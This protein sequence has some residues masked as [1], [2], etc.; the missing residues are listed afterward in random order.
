[1]RFTAW[2]FEA[3]HKPFRRTQKDVPVLAADQ[4]LVEVVGCGVCHTD[5]GFVYDGVP[6]RHA[7]P[8]V[9]GHEISGKV[10]DAGTGSKEWVGKAVVLPAVIPCG[11]CALCKKGHSTICAKQIFFGNDMD[12]GFASHVVAPSRGLCEVPKSSTIDL[13]SLSVLAD[14]ITTPF[15][16]IKRA[17]LQ[18]GDFAIF[19]GVGGVGAFGVQLAAAVG[20]T[21]VAIDVDPVRLERA[22]SYGA[23]LTIN[24]CDV[25]EKELKKRLRAYAKE[26]GLP[27]TQWKIFETS[28]TPAGQKTAFAML[29]HGAHLAIVGYTPRNVEICLSHL[30]AFDARAEGN[31]GCPPEHYPAAL[32]MILS[33]KLKLEPFIERHPMSEVNHVFHALHTKEITKRVVLTPDF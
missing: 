13:A 5:L 7:L 19:V 9:L 29:V 22:A 12:G 33:G 30:M 17:G 15:Q 3:P 18:K 25:E 20:A 2:E 31:W 10:V 1:M 8:L 21:V 27:V 32:D 28:G 6:T 14:A 11:E 16:A 26:K 24:V 23:A 4:V